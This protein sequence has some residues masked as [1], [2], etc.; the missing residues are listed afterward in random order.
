MNNNKPQAFF[1]VQVDFEF[2]KFSKFYCS[3]KIT[4]LQENSVVLVERLI[5]QA[6]LPWE[7]ILYHW[8]LRVNHNGNWI[9][10]VIPK[11]KCWYIQLNLARRALQQEL[12][13]LDFSKV[14][15]DNK[16]LHRVILK[17]HMLLYLSFHFKYGTWGFYLFVKKCALLACRERVLIGNHCQKRV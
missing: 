17:R 1:L 16:I 7:S 8:I 12:S 6:C 13:P 15:N 14:L 4:S 11:S 9:F 5:E 2:S 3:T 10:A